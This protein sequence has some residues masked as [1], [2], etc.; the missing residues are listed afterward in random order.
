MGKL[1]PKDVTVQIPPLLLLM[2]EAVLFANKYCY[3][4]GK[5]VFKKEVAFSNNALRDLSH[6]HFNVTG[7][8][9]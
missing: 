6:L 1:Q 2:F 5:C 8:G 3:F 4:V 9:L 7:Q